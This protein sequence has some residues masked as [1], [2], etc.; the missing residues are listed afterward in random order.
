M[1][2]LLIILIC[3]IFFRI[4]VGFI[5]PLLVRWYVNKSREKFFRD[6]PQHAERQQ[7][8]EGEMTINIKR[9]SHVRPNSDKLGEYTD[10]EEIKD[11][12]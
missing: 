6:N 8:K 4:L 1:R 7:K 2:L 10:F 12:E 3:Y 5:F 11:T 9:T